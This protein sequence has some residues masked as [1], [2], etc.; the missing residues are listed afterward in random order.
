MAACPTSSSQT[1]PMT[2]QQ[3][4]KDW[5]DKE[6]ANGATHILECP[7]GFDGDEYFGAIDCPYPGNIAIP[8]W[9]NG[10]GFHALHDP[11]NH[12]E[13][14]RRLC[15]EADEEAGEFVYLTRREFAAVSTYK[16]TPDML[17]CTDAM[18]AKLEFAAELNQL[19]Q[20]MCED[21]LNHLIYDLDDDSL[22][23]FLLGTV[24]DSYHYR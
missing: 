24:A 11:Y 16:D 21:C 5:D 17:E 15:E 13:E 18:M 1:K 7:Y 14:I 23:F 3:A 4:I 2:L 10:K 22:A 8:N 6:A 20:R 9:A 12:L 19:L